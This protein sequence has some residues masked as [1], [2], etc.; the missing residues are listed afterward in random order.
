MTV[1]EVVWFINHKY[2]EQ[3]WFIE[4][5][6]AIEIYTTKSKWLIMKNDYKNFHIYTLFHFNNC[7]GAH[8]HMQRRGYNLDYLVYQAIMHDNDTIF[9]TDDTWKEFNRSWEMYKLGREIEE[10]AI[11]WNWLAGK[12]NI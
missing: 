2:G 8:Y 4:T 1:D 6:K 9:S 11:V 10:R 12:S 7:E 3:A 5:D